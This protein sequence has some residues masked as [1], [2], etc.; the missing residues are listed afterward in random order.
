MEKL[1]VVGFS[2]RK[3]KQSKNA[4]ILL[5]FRGVLEAISRSVKYFQVCAEIV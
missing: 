2:S 3:V 5:I 4:K 1:K